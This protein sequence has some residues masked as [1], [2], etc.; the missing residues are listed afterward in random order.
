MRPSSSIIACAVTAAC[1][2]LGLAGCNYAQSY[3]A[4][5]GPGGAPTFPP[6]TVTEAPIPT[7]AATPIGITKGADGNVWFAEQNGDKIAKIV[8]STMAIT[9]YPVPTAA[10]APSD[11]TEGPNG[12]PNV[13]FDEVA[14]NKIGFVTPAGSFTE[15]NVPTPNAGPIGL[16][17]DP[18]GDLWFGEFFA[19]KIASITTSGVVT[20]YPI[21][22]GGAPQPDEV[23]IAPDHSVWFLDPA[24]NVVGHMTFPGPTFN[25][26]ALLTPANSPEFMTNGADGNLWFTELGN[27]SNGT[28]CVIGR[29]N[30]GPSP[31]IS[32]FSNFKFAQ[33]TPYGD[34]CLGI[35]QG[36]DGNIWFAE[37][38]VGGIG[39][40][41]SNGTITE[42]GVPGS[43]TTAVG[44]ANGPDGDLWFTDGNLGLPYAIGTN[45]VGKVQ[46]SSLPALGIRK[47]WK[48]HI[49]TTPLHKVTLH[50][51]E[52]P[53]PLPLPMR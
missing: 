32:E 9:E 38:G 43:G 47:Q 22:Y 42:W 35:A 11:V 17:S 19:G 31:T 5:P 2:A 24:D 16:T 27:P 26:Y 30:L 34:W 20:E 44:L 41:T 6:G 40:I 8:P 45:Q 12:N 14:G 3:P 29:V 39:R 21:N 13:W 52:R 51:I 53:I 18:T 49:V 25:A 4:L 10:S 7:A 33:P 1:V 37:T 28:Y 15:F 23:T 48:A 46:I 50:G 36:S